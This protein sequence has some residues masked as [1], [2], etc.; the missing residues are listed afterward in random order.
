M[1]VVLTAVVI[2]AAFATGWLAKQKQA[3]AGK[4]SPRT[5][6][7]EESARD[8]HYMRNFWNYDGS[9]QEEYDE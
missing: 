2:A 8:A 9:E 4:P 6:S 3:Q 7:R 5:A 1:I